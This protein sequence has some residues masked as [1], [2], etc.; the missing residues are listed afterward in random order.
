METKLHVGW[1]GLGKMG[2]P[3]CRRLLNNNIPVAVY[4]LRA[5]ATKELAK[6]GAT[7]CGSVAALSRKCDLVFSMVSDDE[8]L[9][10]VGSMLDPA[11]T[12]VDMSTVSLSAS[13]QVAAGRQ[14]D[15]YLR[16]PVSG[17]VSLA[18]SGTLTIYCSGTQRAFAAAQSYL[19]H[20]GSR[21]I[22]CG[23]S[24]EARA[25]K[26][27]INII[28][29]C[30]PLLVGEAIALATRLGVS[31]EMIVDAMAESAV[32][33]PLIQYKADMLKSLGWA[34]TSASLDTVAK[35]AGLAVREGAAV[36]LA[37]PLSSMVRQVS[38]SFQQAGMGQLDFFALSQ[39]ADS[40]LPLHD[41]MH[42]P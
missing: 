30:V 11:V 41:R 14:A 2:T 34:A 40:G 22:F 8:A 18:E 16:A 17:S 23:E 24:E 31:R 10:K 36:D 7:E 6:Q 1:I 15:R 4:D 21:V 20:L 27:A 33:S 25:I 37:L 32:S 35:D 29:G 26:L 9:L 12:L 28:A 13:R 39:W 19:C 5:T 42:K 38:A 3:M